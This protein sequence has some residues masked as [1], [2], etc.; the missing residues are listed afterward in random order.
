MQRVP[1]F[2]GADE[3][4]LRLLVKI[5]VLE[6]YMP[7]EYIVRKDDV[8]KEML[9]IQARRPT[10]HPPPP[11]LMPPPS[12]FSRLRRP[13]AHATV[14]PSL[15][16]G[17]CHVLS[18]DEQTILFSLRRGQFFGE[19]ALSER[20]TSS[21]RRHH[22]RH[23]HD[24]K[25]RPPAR[26][27]R[28]SRRRALADFAR[29]RL[30]ERKNAEEEKS[31]ADALREAMSALG[32]FVPPADGEGEGDERRGSMAGRRRAR[33]SQR[34]AVQHRQNVSLFLHAPL[35][36]NVPIF[37]GAEYGFIQSLADR[38]EPHIFPPSESSSAARS[39][40]RCS[41]AQRVRGA[42]DGR[43]EADLPHHRRDVL[44]GGRRIVLGQAT[45]SVRTVTYCVLSLNKSSLGEAMRDYPKE[46]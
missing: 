43:R 42:G 11:A 38:L 12:P 40:A 19:I 35:L 28:L 5:A 39:A 34:A 23:A 21:C 16:E 8:G 2:N 27:A 4:F 6:F 18:D 29:R 24:P 22:L 41:S 26:P 46:G 13:R 33:D 44:R 25:A 31:K 15:Q 20:R 7:L 3:S 9:F 30:L 10:G 37:K 32:L 1:L 14:A 36:T 17:T 45:A